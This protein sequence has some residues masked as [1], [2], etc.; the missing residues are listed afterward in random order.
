MVNLFFT[1]ISFLLDGV[2]K[3]EG[4]EAG[5]LR[6]GGSRNAV[7]GDRVRQK[8]NEPKKRKQTLSKS[9]VN[10]FKTNFASITLHFR[11]SKFIL[12]INCA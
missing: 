10:I 1:F 12:K 3:R 11:L 4:A 7:Y 2:A 8:R 6:A 5:G 9:T